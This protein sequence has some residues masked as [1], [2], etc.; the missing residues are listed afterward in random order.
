MFSG[1]VVLG[2]ARLAGLDELRDGDVDD[3]LA[4]GLGAGNTQQAVDLPRSALARRAGELV[5]CCYSPRVR[6]GTRFLRASA[7]LPSDAGPTVSP[8]AVA[9]T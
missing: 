2:V 8:S 1:Q 5:R 3:A 7:P 9:V 6:R 4:A